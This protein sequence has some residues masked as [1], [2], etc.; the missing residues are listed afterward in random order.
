[1]SSADVVSEAK[2]P[3]GLREAL[4]LGRSADE[5]SDGA[6]V[7]RVGVAC[8]FTPLHVETFVRAY[9]I[10]G[11]PDVRVTTA[12]GIYGD[13]AGTI[14]QFVAEG[15]DSCVVVLEWA[16]LDPRLGWR[17]TVGASIG[18]IG[19]VT[20]TAH[21]RLDRIAKRLEVLGSRCRTAVILPTLDLPAAYDG[22]PSGVGRLRARL[23]LLLAEFADRVVATP[24][25]VLVNWETRVQ[26]DLRSEIRSGFPHPIMHASALAAACV[27]E[28]LPRVAKKG[29]ITDLDDTLWRGLVGE[30]GPA[31]VTWDLDSGSHAHALYQQLL[32]ALAARGVLLAVASKN[33]PDV[34]QAALERPDLIVAPERIFP[35][36]ASWGPKSQSVDAILTAWNIAA[37]DVVFVDDSPMELAEVAARH[38][39]ITPI[40]FP[41]A[42]QGA[43]AETLREIAALLW[44]EDVTADDR[45]RLDSLRAAG[46]VAQARDGADDREGFLIDLAGRITINATSSAWQA[47][48]ARELVNKTNQ[49]NLN[50]RRFDEAQ[51]QQACTREGAFLWSISYEDRFGPLG[52]IGV[53]AGV[54]QGTVATVDCWVLS[55]RAFSRAIEH[56][57]LAALAEDFDT[58][59]FD[60]HRTERNG[61]LG[62]LLD[63]VAPPDM[64]GHRVLDEQ[65][66]SG[67]SPTAV[68]VLDRSS[69]AKEVP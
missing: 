7:H 61:V 25:L 23:D 43:V 69:D 20:T 36:A 63:R 15:V 4:K 37:S 64:Q 56:H 21:Q 10:Q 5:R 67:D 54:M 24:G 51:W 40:R 14:D 26:R 33:D 30:I 59:L 60:F 3:L 68:H 65:L 45:L 62:S 6:A 17:E 8:S 2:A 57:V 35:V 55:C 44:R 38:P 32:A 11:R 18:D 28:L 58:V 34:V 1:M 66:L 16:D 12:T 49:F 48:R 42:D 47:P 39:G 9:L 41:A 53:L 22:H 13:L 52:V 29:L 27:E 19:D 31:A 46:A 50:G